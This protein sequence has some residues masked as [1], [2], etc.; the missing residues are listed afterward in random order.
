MGSNEMLD[1]RFDIV[2]ANK[3]EK[4]KAGTVQQVVPRHSTIHNVKD[5]TEMI[6]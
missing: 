6:M 1:E 3:F 2:M 5:R 4:V